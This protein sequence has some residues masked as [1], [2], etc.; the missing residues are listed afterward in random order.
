MNEMAKAVLLALVRNYKRFLS[1]MLPP[2]CRYVPSCSEYAAE[3]IDRFGSGRG[4]AM[5][6]ARLLRCHPWVAGGFDPVPL[7][8]TA[9]P[10]DQ[11]RPSPNLVRCSAADHH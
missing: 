8:E 11:H 9:L 4:T 7:V 1:P 3:A 6:V 10:R 2:S 5:A